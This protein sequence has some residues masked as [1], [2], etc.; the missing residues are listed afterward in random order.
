[1]SLSNEQIIVLAQ[2]YGMK[3]WLTSPLG[4]AK[5]LLLEKF[6]G[7]YKEHMESLRAADDNMRNIAKEFK[8]YVKEVDR[9]LKQRRYI[10][11]AHWAGKVNTGVRMILAEGSKISNL[12]DEYLLEHLGEYRDADLKND[13]F[14]KDLPEFLS[15]TAGLGD[16]FKGVSRRFLET[17]YWRE[18]RARQMAVQSLVSNLKIMVT[19]IND[20]LNK[21]GYARAKGKISDWTHELVRINQAQTR[22]QTDFKAKYDRWLAPLVSSKLKQEEAAVGPRV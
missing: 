18:T 21:M 4:G 5:R 22:F 6:W 7:R 14:Q 8:N 13:Y 16:M 20:S 2:A 3:H 1:M 11:V 19:F 9:A 12:T 17:L 15:A 10:D